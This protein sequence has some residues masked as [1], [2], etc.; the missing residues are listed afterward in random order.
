MDGPID[1]RP[2]SEATASDEQRA[3]WLIRA[4]A[5]IVG[6][7]LGLIVIG[8]VLAVGPLRAIGSVLGAILAAMFCGALLG[9]LFGIPRS[10][11]AAAPNGAQAE[12]GHN[13]GFSHNTNL[14]QISDWLTKIV[15]GV[16][17]VQ[18]NEIIARFSALSARVAAEWGLHQGQATAGF[19]LLSALLFGFLVS[20]IWTRTAFVYYL[21]Y[22]ETVVT[23]ER[24]RRE[25]AEQRAEQAEHQA[26][27]AERQA[28]QV[29]QQK[30]TLS[31]A[32]N[33]LAGGDRDDPAALHTLIDTPAKSGLAQALWDS[34]PNKGA[35][36][37]APIAGNK[38]LS[39]EADPLDE[40]CTTY[41]LRLVVRSLDPARPL[42]GSV[43]FHLHPTFKPTYT[44]KVA[45]VDGVAEW[46][47]VAG[48]AFTVG[49]E[50]EDGT[51]L[52]LDLAEM[53]S[54]SEAFRSA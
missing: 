36:G 15:V 47:V 28:Q 23:G 33:F 20:Y 18:A 26:R 53:D 44:R 41:A 11:S 10:L 14:E 31:R 25:A 46:R 5:Y 32:V 35:F 45:A 21:E 22:N 54:F 6:A 17:L 37:G 3:A 34:D 52:E 2:S 27:D 50:T 29:E 9:F 7:L 16:G 43:V 49:A 12:G 30:D 19:V 48:G 4:A 24:R 42:Q 38:E 51:R 39:V 8:A 1:P 40:A 13:G